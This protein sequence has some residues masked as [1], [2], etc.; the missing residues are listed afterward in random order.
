MAGQLVQTKAYRRV[1]IPLAVASVMMVVEP[2]S[3][4]FVAHVLAVEMRPVAMLA[5]EAPVNPLVDLGD[6][7]FGFDVM[8][9][10]GQNG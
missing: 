1:V 2:A 5:P 10:H 4:G 7:V 8:R 9:K 3:L 6:A